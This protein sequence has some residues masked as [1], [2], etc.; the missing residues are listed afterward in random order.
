MLG[1]PGWFYARPLLCWSYNPWLREVRVYW[2]V[3]CGVLRI[4]PPNPEFQL[5]VSIGTQ[6]V[7][8]FRIWD[9]KG[10]CLLIQGSSPRG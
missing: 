4:N 1:G 7:C 2:T 3:R 6:G 9:A 10:I 5:L 8:R